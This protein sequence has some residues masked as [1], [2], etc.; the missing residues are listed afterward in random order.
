[1]IRPEPRMHDTN[2]AMSDA[3]AIKH[4]IVASSFMSL[5]AFMYDEDAGLGG[6]NIGKGDR[7]GADAGDGDGGGAGDGDKGVDGVGGDSDGCGGITG[8][9]DSGGRGGITQDTYGSQGMQLL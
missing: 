8:G 3:C 5:D 7:S 9:G 2:A 6:L 4:R 1:M